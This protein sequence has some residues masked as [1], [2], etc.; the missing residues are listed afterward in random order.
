MPI[1]PYKGAWP[2]IAAGAFIAPTA[3][4]AGDV[5]IA[6]GA[7][8]WFGAVI[9]ADSAAVR[10][11]ERSNVQDNCVIHVDEGMPCVI[12]ADVTLGHGA[13]V[14][15]ATVEDGAM[16]GMRATVLNGAVVGAGCIVAAQ[17]LVPEGKHVAAGQLIM[18]VPGKVAR[19]VTEAE[20]ARVAEG[21]VHYQRYALEYR[22]ALDQSGS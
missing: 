16:I 9:R 19:A 1:L 13:V 15:G 12:G 5:T 4:I 6:S 10:I 22:A 11:G 8:V 7:S 18:G 2:R 20:H 21:V 17:A 14:H 3:T